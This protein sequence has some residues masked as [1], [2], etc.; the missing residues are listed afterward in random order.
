MNDPHVVALLYR[1]EHRPS[2]AYSDD[3]E[4]VDHE[5][6]AFRITLKDGTVR[7][8]FK[9]HYATADSARER[10]RAYIEN[11]EMDACLRGRPGDFRL[12]YREAKIIDRNPPPPTPGTVSGSGEAIVVQVTLGEAVGMAVKPFYPA[13]PSGLVLKADDPDVATMYHRLDGYYSGREKLPGMAYFCLDLFERHNSGR[14]A[15]AARYRISRGV[16]NEIGKLS[17]TRGGADARKAEGTATD[18]SP[19][20]SRFLEEGIKAIIR[21]AAEVA[22]NPS[23]SLPKIT[24]ADLPDRS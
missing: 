19:G 21:R 20:E 24:L 10:V 1:V 8:E 7:F 9:E 16:L 15:A 6:L 11:W 13:P 14:A 22:Q 5:E 23:G 3:A 12:R 2:M 17:T 18:L 4:P